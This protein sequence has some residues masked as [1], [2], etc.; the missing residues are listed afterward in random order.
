VLQVSVNRVAIPYQTGHQFLLDYQEALKI[1][2]SSQSLIKQG[3]NSYI[4][5]EFKLNAEKRSQSLIKQG[6]NSYL[7]EVEIYSKDF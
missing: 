3:I 7:E 2:R 6:I 1:F 4:L 5:R